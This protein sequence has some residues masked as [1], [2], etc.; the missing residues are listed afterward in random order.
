MFIVDA[1]VHVWGADTPARPWPPGRAHL[2]QKPYPVT[3]DLVLDG[4]KEAEIDRAVLVPP[5]WEGDRNDLA[6]DA[7]R[8]HADRFAVMGRL[9]VEQ[10]AS[11]ALVADWLA[12]PGMLGMRLTFHTEQQRPWL[13]RHREAQRSK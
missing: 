7:A 13:V 6:L 1:Q 4:M 2:A 5:S 8:R 10:P 9:A 11:R 12:Q 3:P